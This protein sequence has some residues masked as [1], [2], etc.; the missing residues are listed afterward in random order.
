VRHQPQIVVDGDADAY[1][2]EVERARATLCHGDTDYREAS[3]IASVVV[4]RA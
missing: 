4:A 2:A 1:A 3:A